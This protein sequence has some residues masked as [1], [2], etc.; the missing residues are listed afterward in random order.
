M[1]DVPT[2]GFPLQAANG[3]AMSIDRVI[4][5]LV[6]LGN[7]MAS[8]GDWININTGCCEIL[9]VWKVLKSY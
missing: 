9:L 4:A 2:P 7:I 8:L 1:A 3:S 5:V 6:Q